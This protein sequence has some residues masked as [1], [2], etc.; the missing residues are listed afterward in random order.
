MTPCTVIFDIDGVVVDSEQL[1]FDVLCRIA[2]KETKNVSV[3]SLIG[4]SMGETL[5][6]I[7]VPTE[8]HD[9]VSAQIGVVYKDT[10]GTTY[11]REGIRE[12]VSKLQDRG[13]PFGFVSTAPRDICLANIAVLGLIPEPILVSGDDVAHTKPH[14]DP[15]LA[16]LKILDAQ[17]E[18]TVVIE[19]T[20]LGIQA[21]T[22]AGITRVYGWPHALSNEQNYRQAFK[23][24]QSLDD[25]ED[26]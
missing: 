22:A 1:H 12:L 19:D 17:P 5:S 14:P 11:L 26:L 7:G 18:E 15:Y 10:L 6:Q 2:P 3:E 16:M 25:I 20:D 23:V 21:A 24:I 4:L 13:I 8:R 9:E